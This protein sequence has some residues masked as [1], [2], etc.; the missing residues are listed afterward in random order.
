MQRRTAILV[1]GGLLSLPGCVERNTDTAPERLDASGRLAVLIDGDRLDLSADR[2]QAEYADE[3]S[4]RFHLH[5]GD[6]NWYME[7]R[8]RVT[9]AEGL[10]LLP[11]LE[12]ENDGGEHVLTIENTT[13][14][15][16]SGDDLAFSVDGGAVNPTAYELRDGDELRVRIT[17]DG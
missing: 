14:D 9:F 13:Y 1:A 7:S 8:E 3:G 12:Y 2:F 11:R 5:D 6:D 15:E 17:T 16:R 4:A 10:D